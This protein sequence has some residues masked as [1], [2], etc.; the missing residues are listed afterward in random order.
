MIS[1]NPWS[2]LMSRKQG[3]GKFSDAA[4]WF[5]GRGRLWHIRD[6]G[7]PRIGTTL[8]RQAACKQ[9]QNGPCGRNWGQVASAEPWREGWEWNRAGPQAH[10]DREAHRKQQPEAH[11]R[12]GEGGNVRGC[13]VATGITSVDCLPQNGR[14][15]WRPAA[16]QVKSMLFV[17]VILTLSCA[18]TAVGKHK[19]HN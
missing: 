15:E 5:L 8:R 1:H 4:S 17:T 10:W 11:V 12:G 6:V 3:R 2:F 16:G 13:A 19:L 14:T 9:E 7:A 18:R